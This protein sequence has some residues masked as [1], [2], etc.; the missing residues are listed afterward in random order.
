MDDRTRVVPTEAVPNTVP[1]SKPAPGMKRQA[2]L[3][4]RFPTVFYLREHARHRIPAFGFEATDGGAGRDGG[5]ARNAA[6]LDAIELMPRY[7]IDDGSCHMETE[8]FGRRYSAPFRNC[9]RCWRFRYRRYRINTAL[10]RYNREY[11]RHKPWSR[12]GMFSPAGPVR[13]AAPASC[14]P[15]RYADKAC[16]PIR[17]SALLPNICRC[18]GLRILSAVGN[19]PLRARPGIC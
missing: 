5:I 10:R 14:A 8:L 1:M 18:Y 12:D 19:L 6:A 17:R 15:I 11:A 7:G 16:E 4:R 2:T 9:D 3:R 13:S